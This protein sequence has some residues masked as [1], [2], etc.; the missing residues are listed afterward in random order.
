MDG[1]PRAAKLRLMPTRETVKCTFGR[2][3]PG[4]ASR[5]RLRSAAL[6]LLL[7]GCLDA[8]VEEAP[9]PVPETIERQTFLEVYVDLRNLALRNADG[10]VNATERDS[11]LAV[12]EVAEEDLRLFLEV[13]HGDAELMRDLWNEAES[14]ISLMLQQHGEG[15]RRDR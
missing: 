8:C 2:W 13:H 4:R 14:L 15:P 10:T 9:D 11:V 3:G 12:H 7:F 6:G 1:E 5:P